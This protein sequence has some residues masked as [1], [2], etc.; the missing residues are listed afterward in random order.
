MRISDWSSD[1]C[2]SDLDEK[3]IAGQGTVAL[4]MLKAVPDLDAILVPIGGGG[5]ISGIAIA[6]KAIDPKIAIVGVEATLYPSLQSATPGLTPT[7]GGQDSPEGM[8]VTT[9]GTLSIPKGR[10]A[11]TENK[12][13]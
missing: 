13:P 1:V 8:T 3:I 9:T 7:P 10:P 6:A 12:R 5:I 2:S 4:E 11:G